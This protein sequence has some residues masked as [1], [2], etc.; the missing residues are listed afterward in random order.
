MKNLLRLLILCLVLS[1]VT[2]TG[3][4]KEG[5][6]KARPF[7]LAEATEKL[8]PGYKGDDIKK[9]AAIFSSMKRAK[10]KDEFETT[11]EYQK[12][13]NKILSGI[14]MDKI[15]AFST[16]IEGKYDAD[17]QLLVIEEK[18]FGALYD[19]GQ[20]ATMIKYDEHNGR[21][22][23]ATNAFGAQIK[24]RSSEKYVYKI[25]YYE[26]RIDGLL[27]GETEYGPSYQLSDIIELPV[28][29]AKA[30]NGKIGLLAL[31]KVDVSSSYF[32]IEVETK[33]E[34]PTFDSP[35]ESTTYRVLIPVKLLGI[36]VY[37]IQT[38]EIYVK[39]NATA[40]LPPANAQTEEQKTEE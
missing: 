6:P 26:P 34:K 22:Y 1:C 40:E 9:L 16:P 33:Y 4:A 24:V 25:A 36:W 20:I 3:W 7:T 23:V 28:K 2:T 13:T 21:T 38:G 27:H 12:R 37:N 5:K 17:R 11:E 18:Y 31:C 29:K 14:D 35:V 30:L 15:Y 10:E 32:P 8:P 19:S 39:K